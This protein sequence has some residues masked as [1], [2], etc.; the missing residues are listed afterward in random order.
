MP[1]EGAPLTSDEIAAIKAWLAGGAKAPENEQPELDPRQH[2]AYQSPR[3]AGNDID[4]LLAARLA[5]TG[6][7]AQ[8]ES[9]PEIWLRR[10]YFDLIGL[11]PTTAELNDFQSSLSPSLPP[12]LSPPSQDRETARR[13]D[14]EYEKVV[15][16]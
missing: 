7:Q 6:L 12:P 2:W 4:S 13:R 10:V 3:R 9:P 11:P 8:R 14:E 5:A 16:R 1:P 15:D